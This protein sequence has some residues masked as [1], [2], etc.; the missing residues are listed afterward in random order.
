MTAKCENAEAVVKEMYWLAW[1]ACGGPV[2]MGVLQE[3]PGADRDAVWGNVRSRGD[4]PGLAMSGPGMAVGDYV[5]GRMMKLRLGYGGDWIDLP[6][7]TPTRDY[8]SWCGEYP[9]YEALY[10]AARQGVAQETA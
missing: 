7:R 5:F 9:T 2:G 4:Y 10:D 3:N 6:D 1:Q 8:Q